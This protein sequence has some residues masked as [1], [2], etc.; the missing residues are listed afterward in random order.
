MNPPKG[1]KRPRAGRRPIKIDLKELEKLCALQCADQEIAAFFEVNV[2]TIERRKKQPAFAE[3]MERGRAKGCVSVRRI[4]FAQAANGNVAAAIFLSKN[5]LGYKD[6]FA[7]EHS[8]PDGG[9]IPVTILEALH[10]RRDKLANE[11]KGGNAAGAL[12][13]ILAETKSGESRS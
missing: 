6:Y 1:G 3:A 11:R 12:N 5:L 4:L 9:P 7:N 8:G 10:R 2:R 13:N